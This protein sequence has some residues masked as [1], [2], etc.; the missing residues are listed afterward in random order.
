MEKRKVIFSFDVEARGQGPMRH[1]ILSIGVCVGDAATERVL[2]KARFDFRPLSPNQSFE[3][4]SLDEFWSKNES[5]RETLERNAK[6]AI[7]QTIAFRQLL[8]KWD[9][10]ADVYL[11]CDNPAFDATFIN[12]YL[13]MA[14]LPKLLYKGY[15]QNGKLEYRSVHDADSY[16]RGYFK[17]GIDEVWFSNADAAKE[18]GASAEGHDHMPE[19]DAEVI[20]RLHRAALERAAKTKNGN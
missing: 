8:D 7:Q 9:S 16:G 12:Y 5:L 2:E 3:Q 1:G 11:V 17:Q 10:A 20:Y 15:S 19:N 13:D 4:R 6:D 14:N 18:W